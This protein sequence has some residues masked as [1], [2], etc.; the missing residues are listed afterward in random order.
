MNDFLL[1]E[2]SKLLE[3][4]YITFYDFKSELKPMETLKTKEKFYFVKKLELNIC[5]ENL[6]NLNLNDFL[7]MFPNLIDLYVDLNSFCYPI[8]PV[9]QKKVI[10]TE[11]ENSKIN[12]IKLNL[13]NDEKIEIILN[14]VPYNKLKSFELLADSI[15]IDD[16]PFFSRNDVM[17]ECLEKFHFSL[18]DQSLSI[19]KKT[20][21]KELIKYLHNN[22]DN[23]PNLKEFYFLFNYEK[24]NQ[25][26]FL[27]FIKK[28][29]TLKSLKKLFIIINRKVLNDKLLYTFKELNELFPKINFHKFHQ[30]KIYKLF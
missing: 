25:K 20:K 7:E 26:Y 30:I 22:I 4:L 6:K 1:L 21:K 3:T 29:L 16:F 28:V 9:H 23:M 13:S 8:K 24:I 17:F 11:N 18:D 2:H 27:K 15:D 10:I 19:I 14:C 12:K 5:Y